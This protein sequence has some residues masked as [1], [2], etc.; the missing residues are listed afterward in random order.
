MT[1]VEILNVKT[2]QIDKVHNDPLWVEIRSLKNSQ[3]DFITEFGQIAFNMASNQD[4]CIKQLSKH[5]ATTIHRTCNRIVS[6][7]Q[8]HLFTSHKYMLLGQFKID[9]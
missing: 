9:L 6:L 2:H 8:E 7:Y 3:L 4:K 1:W 5:T